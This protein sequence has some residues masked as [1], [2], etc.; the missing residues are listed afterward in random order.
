MIANGQ[1]TILPRKHNIS[2]YAALFND[3][4][5]IHLIPLID[6]GDT[7]AKLDLPNQ[8]ALWQCCRSIT[9]NNYNKTQLPNSIEVMAGKLVI[10]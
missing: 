8:Q 4:I 7:M 2:Q 9:L 1:G 6:L 3:W 10:A 5:L